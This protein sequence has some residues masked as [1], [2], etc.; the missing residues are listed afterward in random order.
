MI[1]SRGGSPRLGQGG[2][3][4]RL[5]PY[6]AV[7]GIYDTGL[8][9]VFTDEQGRVPGQD[10]YGV[11]VSFGALGYHSWRHT[12]LG[13]SY[14]GETRH[15]SRRT[16]YSGLNQAVAVGVSHQASRR[17]RFEIQ[18]AA[19]TR[20]GGYYGLL[21]ASLY[22]PEFT[23]ATE[24]LLFDTRTHLLASTARMIFQKSARLSLSATGNALMIEPRSRALF[25]ARMAGAGGDVAYRLSRTQ[26]IGVV[27]TFNHFWYPRAFG[28]A[29][30]HGAMLQ[31]SRLLGRFWTLGLGAG[32]YRVES[33]GLRR[34]GLD[35]VIAA[36]IGERFGIE[37]FHR[38]IYVPGF[39]ASLSRQFRRASFHA[40]Y[41]RGISAG[42]GLYLTSARE[43]AGVGVG[44]TGT[45]RL[46]LSASAGYSRLTSLANTLGRHRSYRAGAGLTYRLAGP[47]SLM[48]R[49]DG[50]KYNLGGTGFGRIRYRISAGLTF[51]PGEFPLALW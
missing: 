46:H 40:H 32:G 44:Y 33:V 51:S 11:S 50:H 22:N 27:Y 39:E 31:Y 4:L 15:Y 5:R 13:L 18:Q 24:D 1:L 49:V 2:E 41:Q 20:H 7:T 17:V 25:Q 14:H 47:L 8:T 3:L 48:A 29:E 6:A 19:A 12:T 35:P 38:I 42:N 10:A 9:G 43:S 21:G 30:A 28:N 16:Y 45:R 34:V 26:T 37:V 36:I 23:Q